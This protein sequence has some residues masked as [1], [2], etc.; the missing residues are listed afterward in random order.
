MN[1]PTQGSLTGTTTS[2]TV[3]PGDRLGLIGANGSGKTTLLDIISGA[4]APDTGQIAVSRGAKIGYLAQEAALPPDITLLDE[5]L[6][7][8]PE[9][10]E[11][12]HKLDA[13][14]TALGALAGAAIG[15]VS[16]NMGTGA[17]LGAGTGLVA[18]SRCRWWLSASEI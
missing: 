8:R 5:M 4:A 18:G 6:S 10:L 17:S 7:A 13:S 3:G 14:S 2:F 9:V 16:G 1:R 15:S 11:L 12:R